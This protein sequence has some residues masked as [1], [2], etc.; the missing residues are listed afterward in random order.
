MLA[1][2]WSS[3]YHISNGRV[4][5]NIVTSFSNSSARALGQESIMPHDER[6]AV[7]DEY[8][9]VVYRLWE[10]CWEDGAQVFDVNKGPFGTAY[11]FSKIHKLEFQGKYHKL[12]GIHQTHPSPQRTPMLFQAGAS[13]AGVEFAG[14][15]AEGLFCAGA[16]IERTKAFICQVREV[17]VANGRELDSVKFFLGITP[18]IGKTLEEA[19]EKFEEMR[20]NLHVIGGLA[21]FGGLTG[22]DLSKFPLD[23]E[24]DFKGEFTDFG[25]H[26][27]IETMKANPD[28]DQFGK[29]RPW[30]PRK[31]GEIMA[32]GSHNPI[33]VGTPAM[34]ADVFQKW[35]E[36]AGVDGFN[37]CCSSSPF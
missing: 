7:A 8:M 5:W 15:H 3:L 22:V 12:S 34:V 18:I 26:S 28:T 20:K 9:E 24:F 37:V 16:S 10:G 29:E 35:F 4:A 36:E 32:M 14:K 6:Y 23:E 17:A 11:D 13:K 19:K 27:A 33:P 25:I 1:R 31:V 2:T 21:R 30:T